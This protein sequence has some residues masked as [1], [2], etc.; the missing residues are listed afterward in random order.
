MRKLLS[1]L[2]V[3]SLLLG[4]ASFAAAETA[5]FEGSAQGFGSQVKVK[6]DLDGGK[7]IGLDVDDSGETYS[8]I[9]VS[10]ADSVEKYIAAVIEAGIAPPFHFPACI[11]VFTI[12]E[13]V[14]DNRTAVESF[15]GTVGNDCFPASV[16]I[17]QHDLGQQ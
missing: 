1:L 6:V 8:A 14:T 10:R 9:G 12:L 3:L 13:T 16:G 4:T 7:V 2:L 11:V 15:P 5:S 17:G